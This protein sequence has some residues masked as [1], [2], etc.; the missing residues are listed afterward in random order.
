MAFSLRR[1]FP[2]RRGP[3]PA[4]PGDSKEPTEDTGSGT[5]SH[6]K[7]LVASAVAEAAR[8][9]LRLLLIAIA[10][11]GG[12]YLVRQ[13]WVVV[14][15]GLLALLLSTVLW[16]AARVLRRKL[17]A[18]AA[19]AAALIGGLIPLVGMGAL[20]ATLVS[21]EADDLTDAVVEGLE[22]AQDWTT[23]S[24]L[25][26]DDSDLGNLIDRGTD[27][28][29]ERAQEVAGWT[30]S[31]VSTVGSL[32]LTLVL[33]LVLTFFF[34]K[35][36]P[37]FLPWMAHWL[38]QRSSSHAAELARRVWDA[39]GGF[40]RAQAGVGLAD[41]IGIGLG[42]TLLGVPLALPLAVLT[43]VGAF[44]PIVGALITG[45]LAVLV[46]WVT[47]GTTTALLVAALVLVVQQLE[48]NLLQPVLM[49]RT[50]ALHPAL[51]ILAVTAGGTL[52]GVAGAFL[53][54]PVLA[55]ATAI[56]RYVKE[57]IDADHPEPEGS[58]DP[59]PAPG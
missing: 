20:M 54:V 10:I 23:R 38:P 55:V 21:A 49:G 24:P 9:S 45:L 47:E 7:A 4:E 16:P 26:L 29:Q 14:L 32:L 1:R 31:G 5:G 2:A 11:V 56:A 8:W 58:Q 57:L 48:S 43:F 41:A 46:A 6:D 30:L 33:T 44:V 50:L 12:L 39:L 19:A 13:L 42:L 25:N 3:S 34:L 28:L 35:D 37:K 51:V 15:P 36:G 22:D 18:S 59:D 40:I 27:E 53:A 17:P 52:S